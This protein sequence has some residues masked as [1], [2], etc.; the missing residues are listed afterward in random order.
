VSRQPDPS[1]D[2]DPDGA[3]I[4]GVILAGGRATRMGGEDKGLVPL[5]GR[6]MVQHVI[7]ALEPQVSDIVINA[8]R[9]QAEYERYGYRV[10]PDLLGGYCGP[11]AGIAT[12]LQIARTPFVLTSP[13]DSPFV[14]ADLA[15]RLYG[16]LMKA[17][18]DIVI[19]HDGERL[20]PVFALIRTGLLSSLLGYLESGERKIEPWYRRHPHTL[21]DFSDCPEAFV[22]LNTP[23]ELA[24]A[25]D[26][27]RGAR[28]AG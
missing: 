15:A 22:N 21:C 28:H 10:L 4:T 14:P 6:A 27:L 5:A 3:E 9:N 24:A 26:R 16:A 23:A 18:A 17:G 2:P 1:H 13:C 20:Q 25:E 8:N 11:L 7:A 12:A 19:A